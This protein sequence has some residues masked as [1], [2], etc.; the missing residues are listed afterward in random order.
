MLRQE[1]L[2]RHL[3]ITM[4]RTGVSDADMSS[5]AAAKRQEPLI[6]RE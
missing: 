1:L 3:R 2:V 4:A 6:K 5:S